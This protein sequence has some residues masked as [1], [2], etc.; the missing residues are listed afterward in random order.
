MALEQ[1]I[2]DRIA[3][4]ASVSSKQVL[5][6]IHLLDNE[7]TVPFIARYRKEVTGNLD[8]VQI[9]T[10]SERQEY[11][12]SLLERRE[13]IL[14]SIEAQRKLTEELKSGIL[15]CYEKA[16]LEDIYLPF[17][18]KKKTKAS[19]AIEK[20]L[21]PLARYLSDQ[22][23]G[24]QSIEELAESYINSEKN[25]NTREEAIEGALHIVAEWVSEELEVR[26][27]I[28]EMFLKEGMVVSKV[29]KDKIDQKTK[30]EMYY[31]FHEAVSK[32]PSHR[33]LAIRRGV[34]E[35]VLNHNIEIDQE[36]AVQTIS[37]RLLKE[38]DSIFSPFLKTAIKDSYDRLLNPNLQSEI[39]ALL[40]ERSDREA[41]HVFEENLTN[42]LLSPPAGP[43][44]VMG[45]DPG[46]RTGCK[47]AVVDTT[48]KF[49]EHATIYPTEPRID[50]AGSEKTLYRLVQKHGVQA[51]AIGNGTGSREADNFIKE[52]LRKY[53]NGEPLGVGPSM[54]KKGEPESKGTVADGALPES[55]QAEL[56]GAVSDPDPGGSEAS[57]Q[58]PMLETEALPEPVGEGNAVEEA[59]MKGPDFV[60]TL[61]V[62][63]NVPAE[64][65]AEVVELA[66]EPVPE[67]KRLSVPSA[68]RPVVETIPEERHEI[69]S[70]IVN[71]SGASVYSASDSA[72]REFPKLDLTVRGAISIARRLQDPLA[73]LVKIHPKSIGVGQYQHD[74]DQ[75]RLKDGLEAAVESC[76]NR[77]GVDL[78]MA[79]YELLRYCSGINQRTAKAIVDYRNSKGR[80]GARTHLM[81]VPGF[82][83]K[84]F[85]QA[86]GFLRIK[87]G[88]NPL[89]ATAVHPES[90]EVVGKIAG[91]LAL[92]VK[93]LIE[94][95]RQVETLDL[96][97]FVDDKAGLY[98]LNDI[99]QELL[100]PGRDP[101]DKFV[102]P[103]FREDVKDVADLES[104]MILEGT[105]TNVTNFGAFVDIGVHQ[106]GLVHVSELSDRFV[107]DPR[108]AVHVGQI[109]KVKVIG[110]DVAMKRISLSIK[111][112]LPERQKEKSV[113]KEKD[114]QRA[115]P[116]RPLRASAASAEAT[117]K[118]PQIQKTKVPFS[119]VK[120]EK[121]VS[122]PPAP[123]R[124]QTAKQYVK[125]QQRTEPKNKP[126]N[127]SQPR[128]AES[129]LSVSTLPFDE[130]IRL[131]QEKFSGIR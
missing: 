121:L 103:A 111:A 122:P 51:I 32:I 94:N 46:F 93:D 20:G 57:D 33:V 68:K 60:E 27:N 72:R 47:V 2:I 88:E 23:A 41:I 84:S 100:K 108:D 59:S 53:K 73:E 101:R 35:Q 61:V 75:K 36:K 118:A 3:K 107:Q 15:A 11:Y 81:Q 63:E 113:Q 92:S 117:G 37:S 98:T 120:K 21:E 16:A 85:E 52:F 78:N 123:Q 45:V 110:V 12:K 115:K 31:D 7:A 42:L 44:V 50:I 67:E 34:K 119:A 83:E 22:A 105:V 112:L 39:R 6:T 24:D 82:G 95:N 124:I 54:E 91:S 17:K 29:N 65:Q 96:Q 104:G 62:P 76:V 10:I 86:A 131:L 69:F 30:F 70:V 64:A 74:V 25:V 89:D 28:R 4:E 48:G 18:P 114:L 128:K 125:P 109:V 14:N 99:R 56:L 130:Q 40:K 80:F 19:L 71:E 55:P 5:A 87:D 79:S 26:K 116:S 43:V 13:S 49:L 8:E 58:A 90:Y 1:V 9:R 102:V 129:P 66:P 126:E 127:K 97:P 38:G 77:V 106:D